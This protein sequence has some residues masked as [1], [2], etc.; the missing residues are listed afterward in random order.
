MT[1]DELEMSWGVKLHQ[2]QRKFV[3]DV[4]TLPSFKGFGA[5]GCGKTFVLAFIEELMRHNQDYKFPENPALL[6]F[7]SRTKL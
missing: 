7:E 5:I 6:Q 2:R 1:I 4:L 3:E